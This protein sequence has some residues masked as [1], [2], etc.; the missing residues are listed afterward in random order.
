MRAAPALSQPSVVLRSDAPLANILEHMAPIGKGAGNTDSGPMEG[1]TQFEVRVVNG[2]DEPIVWRLST[3]MLRPMSFEIHARVNGRRQIIMASHYPFTPQQTRASQGRVLASWPLVLQ[4]GA[5]ATITAAFDR[6][7]DGDIF[8]IRFEPEAAYD[9]RQT[10]MSFVHGGYL[11]AAVIFLSFFLAF[12]LL[13]SSAPARAYA[14]YF[15]FLVIL[16]FHS[17]G[18]TEQL[19][20]PEA[21]WLYFPLF[22]LLQVSIMLAYLIFAVSFLRA[23]ER[24]P[25][26]L[27][28]TRIYVVFTASLA[29]LEAL[30]WSEVFVLIVDV[31]AL[32]FLALG[33]LTAYLAVR[34]RH[35]GARFFASG[36]GLLLVTGVLN[37]VASDVAH[38]ARNDAVD[39]LTLGLQLADAFVFASAII[40][41]TY[42]L[43]RDRDT[44]LQ[45]ELAASREKLAMSESLRAAEKDREHAERLAERRRSQM[46]ATSHDLRQPLTSLKLVLEDAR[47]ASPEIAEK[48]RSGLDYLN[49]VLGRSLED[50]RPAPARPPTRGDEEEAV[51]L[52]L[53]FDTV[54]RMFG[55]EAATKGLALRIVPTT[56][57]ARAPTIVLIRMV[58]NLVSNAIKYT[59]SGRVLIGARRNGGEITIEVRDTGPGLAP[60]TVEGLLGPYQRGATSAGTM[61]EGLG[62]AIVRE[63]CDSHGFALSIRSAEGRGSTFALRGIPVDGRAPAAKTGHAAPSK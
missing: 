17:Y 20:F 9:A 35:V 15:V 39:A 37:Y 2:E 12:S 55:A 1:P 40:A 30:I 8:P 34:E 25:K 59:P 26:L 16:N 28:I 43:R 36:Y 19:F 22:R 54:R 60:R 27:Q 58:S 21:R 44:A 29:L 10:I 62:L 46:A 47:D 52:Q 4:P 32:A 6:P 24:Y 3:E 56:L 48:L 7:P 41:Q 13:L 11:G 63:L 50:T 61:G 14:L 53:V 57:V 49:G 38:A 18:H 23:R 45:A 5:A 51:P 42:A 31:M 33:T